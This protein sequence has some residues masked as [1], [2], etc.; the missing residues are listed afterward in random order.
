MLTSL[1]VK[2][3]TFDGVQKDAQQE[4]HGIG[5]GIEHG[6]NIASEHV[7]TIAEAGVPRYLTGIVANALDWVEDEE[8]KELIWEMASSRLSERAGRNGMLC[9]GF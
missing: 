1:T 3:P 6:G 5:R 4:L 7:S 2:P 8:L 9:P